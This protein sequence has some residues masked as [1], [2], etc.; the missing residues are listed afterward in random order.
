[1]S[2]GRAEGGS[3]H[4]EVRRGVGRLVGA[5]AQEPYWC[6][7]SGGWCSFAVDGIEDGGWLGPSDGLGPAV[8]L[9]DV[10]VN[11]GLEIH[12]RGEAA[13]PHPPSCEGREEA[14]GRVYP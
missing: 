5:E 3:C 13:K 9:G 6:N 8:V 14:L 12:D 4:S 11:R 7:A 10:A 1:M 2:T